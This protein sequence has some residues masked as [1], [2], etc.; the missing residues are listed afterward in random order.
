MPTRRLPVR[1]A[2]L[3]KALG[4]P[5]RLQILSV[6]AQE[7][8]CVCHLE[9]RLKMRQAYLSQQLAVLR[10]AGLVAERRMGP[11]VYYRARR[12]QVGELI[13]FVRKFAGSVHLGVPEDNPSA[14]S[15]PRC[16]V[17]AQPLAESSHRHARSSAPRRAG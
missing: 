3:F 1:E 4:H 11:Y 12:P 16:V 15:C 14:C 13:E 17:L 5:I 7:E 8:A 2:E 10:E 6:L 9:A